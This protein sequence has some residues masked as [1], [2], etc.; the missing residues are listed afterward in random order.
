MD[1]FDAIIFP[2]SQ[3]RSEFAP[4]RLSSF[5][6][7]QF[8]HWFL[9]LRFASEELHHRLVLHLSQFLL[10]FIVIILNLGQTCTQRSGVLSF[11][12]AHFC[13]IQEF[14]GWSVEI[15]IV[16][17][18]VIQLDGLWELGLFLD[19]L[20]GGKQLFLVVSWATSLI[21]EHDI[22]ITLHSPIIDIHIV[23]IALPITFLL[24]GLRPLMRCFRTSSVDVAR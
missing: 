18:V 1:W 12:Q 15:R 19:R 5:Y 8:L 16:I 17:K 4:S 3:R 7:G 22:I 10:D 23:V 11:N 13:T 14:I 21:V 9:D 20:S 6:L 24:F 2:Q